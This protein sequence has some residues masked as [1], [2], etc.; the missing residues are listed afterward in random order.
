MSLEFR[1]VS[2]GYGEDGTSLLNGVNLSIGAGEFVGLIGPNGVG[3][4]TLLRLAG[5][6][7]A[8]ASGSVELQGESAAELPRRQ[9]ARRVALVPQSR[10]P[11]FSYSVLEVVLMGLHAQLSRFG[12]PSREQRQTALAELERLEIDD[13]ADR[14]LATLS[15][16]EAQRVLMARAATSGAKGWL[17]D[18]PTASLDPKH[19]LS[20]VS[21]V[22]EHVDTG[23]WAL[24]AMHDISLVEG[25]FDRVIVLSRGGIVADGS[26]DTVLTRELLQDVY[27]VDARRVEGWSFGGD[28]SGSSI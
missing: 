28:V 27:G 23:G 8:P 20:L 5:G 1:D 26:P 24:A 17:L 14:S 22:R 4:T 9:A 3:K 25:R 16:G 19:Q 21:R 11:V 13:L 2:F 6:L 12:A 7:L 15:G 10:P 18:E